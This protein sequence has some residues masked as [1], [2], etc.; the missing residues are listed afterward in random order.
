MKMDSLSV[1]FPVHNE[2]KNIPITLEKAITVLKKLPLREYEVILVENGS[3][4]KSPQV[5]DGLA[6]KYHHV[7]A[8]HLPVGGY[9]YALRA[10][11][12]NAKYEWIVYTDADG[13]FDF[14]EVTKFLEKTD[15]ADV[16][17]SYKIKRSDNLFRVLAAKGWALSLFLFFGLRILDVDTGFKMVRKK[18]IETIPPLESTIGGMVNAELAIRAKRAG[19]K[20]TQ[21]IVH[22]YPRLLGKSTG[23]SP[24]VIIQSYIDLLKLWWELR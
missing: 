24:H 17:Y 1:F 15:E 18:V 2:E 5:V 19:F 21:V 14:S 11:F 12:S 4:D 9:G 23:V 6:K 16:I 13:Q 7:K 3:S 8:L 10:G 20:L 22:H